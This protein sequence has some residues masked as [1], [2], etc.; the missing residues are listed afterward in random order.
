MANG[1]TLRRSLASADTVL[2]ACWALVKVVEV[3]LSFG[4][5]L[6]IAL[7]VVIAGK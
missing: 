4:L 2:K 7:V 5:V 6:A 3:F 1:Y